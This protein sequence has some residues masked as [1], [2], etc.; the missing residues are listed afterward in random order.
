MVIVLKKNITQS[1]KDNLKSFLA[2]KQFKLN[3][4]VGEEETILAAVG[5]V[6]I[7]LRE[8]EIQD[9][10]SKVVPIS[11]PYKLAS[12]EFKKEDTVV[13]IPNN[14]GQIIKV[15]GPRI[16]SLA[17][18]AVVESKTQIEEI[19]KCVAESGAVMLHAD[20]YN[21]QSSPYAFQGLGE[22]GLS[23]LKAAGNKYG[24]PV[25]TEI[26]DASLIPVMERYEIDVYQVGPSNMQN[27]E[28]LKKLGS[29]NKPVILKRGL[30]ATLEDFL[31]SAEY[32]MAN[33][34]EK[35]IL[36]EQGIRTF[37]KVTRNTL[38][39]SA[40]PVLR[41]LTHLPII[42]DPSY[43][44]GIRDKIPQM[45]LASIAAGA[46]GILVE[47]HNHP[48][49]ALS[50]GAQSLLPEMFERL[51]HNVTAMAPVA[52]RSVEHIW[53]V[54]VENPKT[55]TD[56]KSKKIICAYNGNPGAYAHQAIAR[57]FDSSNVEA[58]PEKS[59]GNVFQ[60]VLDGKAD[61]GMIP[62]ENT[63]TG[64]IYQNYDNLAR[65]ADVEIVG[66]ETLNI[67]HALLGIKGTDPSEIKN[68]YSHPQGL[69]QCQKY[70]ESKD[71]KQCDSISTAT[72][73]KYVA[74]AGSK[75]N[76]AIASAV[77]ASLYG[78]EILQEDIEDN[79][80]NFT[81]F[82]VIAAKGRKSKAEI[83]NMKPTKAIIMFKIRHEPGALFKCL[84]L[85]AKDKLNI[86]HLESRPIDGENWTYWFYVEMDL[87]GSDVA[88][89]KTLESLKDKTE[90][91]RLL[92]CY[93]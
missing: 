91:I 60:D 7:D 42:V 53:D 31:M 8:V 14:R 18:P 12:R 10:V 24:L 33:G 69:F 72:A 55:V 16:V 29:I 58:M 76:V 62:I 43:A 17:G 63:T 11:K 6:G 68:V 45:A 38:D 90:D 39:L 1:Q 54:E 46:D 92:G 73:A 41:G 66:T 26:V 32:L 86:T 15:G 89:E 13:E 52:G 70:L 79:P 71:W 80:S 87:S 3:E 64:S 40:V 47:C 81:R 22:E 5:K 4:I 78:L 25:V 75:E 36:C 77:N 49:K 44:V 30:S 67:R 37:E 9:G 50:D 84:E 59:F 83:S 88:L 28:L 51:M 19:A 65:F 34:C 93:A 23:L 20:A 35:V 2:N 48:E 56:R 74:Q 27:F 21:S 85:F 82:I 57:Y 61:Y